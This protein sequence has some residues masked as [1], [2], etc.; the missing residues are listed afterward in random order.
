MSSGPN[1]GDIGDSKPGVLNVGIFAIILFIVL[2][3][4]G[5]ISLWKMVIGFFSII[6]Q[7]IVYTVLYILCAGLGGIIGNALRIYAMPSFVF[8]DGMKGLLKARLFWSIAPQSI[9]IVIGFVFALG[10][11]D[12]NFTYPKKAEVSPSVQSAPAMPH[13]STTTAD[14]NSQTQSNPLPEESKSTSEYTPPNS[15]AYKEKGNEY[16]K[17]GNYTQAIENYN[18]A[19]EMDITNETAYNNRGLAYKNLGNHQQAIVDYNKAIELNPKYIDAYVNRANIYDSIGNNKQATVDLK[20]AASLGDK[21]TQEY[22]T[23]K[24][25]VW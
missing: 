14:Q 22:L 10:I 19:I 16:L 13:Q 11:M 21:E 6:W 3:I 1:I 20:M 15:N 2:Y 7:L 24:G 12:A 17:I 4:S 5:L 18:K 8:S 25:I 23:K 9:G